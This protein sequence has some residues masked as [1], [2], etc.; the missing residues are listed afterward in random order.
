V[1]LAEELNLKI[2]QI[3]KWFWDT[4]KKVAEDTKIAMQMRLFDRQKSGVKIDANGNLMPPKEKEVRID[5]TGGGERMTPQQIKTAL[6]IHKLA[7]EKEEDFEKIASNLGIDIEK[8]A[9]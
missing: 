1:E 3:Y 9:L 4:K 6:K 5:G 8:L 7:Q 2:N